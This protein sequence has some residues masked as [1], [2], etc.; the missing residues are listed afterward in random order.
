MIDL[1]ERLDVHEA[2]LV[3]KAGKKKT[4]GDGEA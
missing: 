2:K 4:D 3:D 1:I